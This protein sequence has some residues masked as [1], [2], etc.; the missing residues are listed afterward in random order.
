LVYDAAR[1]QPIARLVVGNCDAARND[2]R[3]P[4][5]EDLATF[6]DRQFGSATNGRRREAAFQVSSST[7]WGFRVF[8]GHQR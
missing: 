2:V 6:V 8:F 3:L 4:S 1:R 7:E 5:F